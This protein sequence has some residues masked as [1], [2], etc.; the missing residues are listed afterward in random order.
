MQPP[1]DEWLLSDFCKNRDESA[2][3]IFNDGEIVVFADVWQSREKI[4]RDAEWNCL[5]KQLLSAT[6]SIRE[7]EQAIQFLEKWF[8][9]SS[10]PASHISDAAV[11]EYIAPGND[12]P[13]KDVQAVLNTRGTCT[14]NTFL[15]LSSAMDVLLRHKLNGIE[16][17]IRATTSLDPFDSPPTLIRIWDDNSHTLYTKS[18]GFRCGNWKQCQPANDFIELKNKE[19]LNLE[20][21][22]N[23]CEDKRS[24]S[25][26]ISFSDNALWILSK[27]SS[28]TQRNC[29]VAIINVASM[30]RLRIPWQ[31]SDSLVQQLGGNLYS[32]RKDG[33]QY[34]WPGHYLVYGCVPS[35][36]I[37]KSFTLGQFKDLCK[38]QNIHKGNPLI[39]R[40][41]SD[42]YLT[43]IRTDSA[44]M[45]V[46]PHELL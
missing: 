20:T 44:V 26:W 27:R 45:R 29:R 46:H 28:S 18:L 39:Q 8:M 9:R 23:H 6:I 14:R 4:Q 41:L 12:V 21:I 40:S 24:P 30:D 7:D 34:A 19:L 3:P 1:C 33:V 43:E 31:R 38:Q 5:N 2:L 37:I 15:E 42:A 25:N 32:S 22:S 11:G 17:P 13:I 36:C 10:D 16:C 35:Q